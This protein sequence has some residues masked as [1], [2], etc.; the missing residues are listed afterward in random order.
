SPEDTAD[1]AT[2]GEWSRRFDMTIDFAEQFLILQK[3][4]RSPVSPIGV[5]QGWSPRTYADAVTKLQNIGYDYIAL[6]GM[7]PLKTSE[8]LACL[9]A[10]AAV[11]NRSTKL[12][13]LGISR[14]DQLGPLDSHGVASFD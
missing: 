6:G 10:V 14:F 11:R 4:G 12:H 5:A 9:E 7:V 1:T 8:I 3:T 13:L 2:L